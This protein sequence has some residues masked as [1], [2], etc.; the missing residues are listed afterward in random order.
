MMR[1]H[2]LLSW[3]SYSSSHKVRICIRVPVFQTTAFNDTANYTLDL[4][5]TLKATSKARYILATKSNST[6]GRRSCGSNHLLSTISTELNMF[7]FGDN[8][9]RNKLSSSTLSPVCTNGRRSRNFTNINEFS[10]SK[11]TCCIFCSMQTKSGIQV[12]IFFER[13]FFKNRFFELNG[14]VW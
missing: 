10:Q 4:P 7:N 6:F 13:K 2:E 3:E 9:D 14:S 11:L 1:P 8:V 12:A 5:G